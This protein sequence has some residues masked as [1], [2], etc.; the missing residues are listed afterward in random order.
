MMH[1]QRGFTLIELMITVVIVGMVLVGINNTFQAQ[2]QAYVVQDRVAEM[3]QNARVALEIM[4]RDIRNAAYDPTKNDPT[5][6][7][8][9][10]GSGAKIQTATATSV[11]FT[12][13]Q[14]GSGSVDASRE[15]L[16][17]R[18]DS[19]DSEIEQCSGTASCTWNPMVDDVQSLQFRYVYEDG[20]SSDAASAGMPNDGDADISN[21]FEDIREVE[22]QIVAQRKGGSIQTLLTKT[23]TSRVQVRNLALR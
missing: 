1:D 15:W 2:E 11:V 21:D 5:S 7:K 3:N 13:D 8:F 17:Y 23:L 6:S 4:S 16:G 19:G 12:Q 22:I 20:G 18:Y 10:T 9:G 14:D